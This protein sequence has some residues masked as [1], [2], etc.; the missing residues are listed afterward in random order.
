MVSNSRKLPEGQST[1]QPQP[2]GDE[3]ETSIVTEG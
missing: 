3:L 2:V 1:A